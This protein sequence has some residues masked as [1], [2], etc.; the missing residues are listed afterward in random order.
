M[1]YRHVV[2]PRTFVFSDLAE[3]MAKATPPR[4]GDRL[5]G[6]AAESAEECVAARWCLAEVPLAEILARPLIPYEADDVTRL[7]L[8]THD[9]A[10]FA[11]I[12]HLTVGDFRE[13]LL[14]APSETL[15]AIAPG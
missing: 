14:T 4:S 15:A 13:F 11:R 7:I 10:A 12:G 9:A 6:L 1:S 3:L 8:D 5:A 2:G